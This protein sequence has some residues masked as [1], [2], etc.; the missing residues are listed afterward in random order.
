MQKIQKSIK[1]TLKKLLLKFFSETIILS[2][3][4]K[5]SNIFTYYILLFVINFDKKTS[6]FP[7]NSS[8]PK[9]SKEIIPLVEKNQLIIPAMARKAGYKLKSPIINNN[10]NEGFSDNKTKQ[11]GNML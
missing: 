4:M 7:T 6:C 11:G 5:K 3:R 8:L 1:K 10:P 9:N 2:S